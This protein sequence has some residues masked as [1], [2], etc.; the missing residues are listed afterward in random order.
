MARKK[1]K[2]NSAIEQTSS[3]LQPLPAEED[4]ATKL[5]LRPNACIFLFNL[6]NQLLLALRINSNNEWQLPQG[7]IELSTPIEENVL[8]EI[9]EEL[10]IPAHKVKI[11]GRLQ[12]TH[13]YEFKDPPNYAKSRWRGQAQSFWVVRFLGTDS[14]ISLDKHFEIEFIDYKWINLGELLEKCSP[15]RR[16]GY[17]KALTEIRERFREL[18]G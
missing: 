2:N 17:A 3:N 18:L 16:N 13:E 1:I 5:P 11:L 7:G 9:E 10:G 14:D 4:S 6:K 8:R 12:V 15:I